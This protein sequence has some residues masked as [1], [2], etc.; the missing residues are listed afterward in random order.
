MRHRRRCRP[1]GALSSLR[2]LLALWATVGCAGSTAQP[3]SVPAR[4]EIVQLESAVFGNSR[5]L[6][7]WLPPLYDA[8]RASA[9]PVIYL[10]DG[11]GVFDE[12][13]A[14]FGEYEWE[15]DET[16]ERLVTERRVAPVVAV[17]IDNAGRRG[18][19]REYL[20]YPDI[21]LSPPEPHP[22]GSL[23]GKF[24]LEEV[25]PLVEARYNVATSPES[26]TLGGSSYGALISLYAA[27]KSPA[28]ASKLLLESPSLYVD[29]RR[30]LS[31]VSSSAVP[32]E[33]VYLGIGTNELSTDPCAPEHPG[34]V[35]AVRDV[36][37]LGQLLTTRGLPPRSLEVVV[38][39]C[40]THSEQSWARRLPAAL[41]FLLGAPRSAD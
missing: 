9:Y 39:D 27:A 2:L 16:L 1:K 28:I 12:S 32:F 15:L 21:H 20:P 31:D 18:R 41:E 38:E 10:N 3:E 24:L 35:E 13:T 30:V 22:L 11:Q 37:E 4:L 23:Y 34:N 6:R 40:A 36:H 19:A 14:Q 5:S 25:F 26:R 29:D 33:R 8:S 17:G 7:I